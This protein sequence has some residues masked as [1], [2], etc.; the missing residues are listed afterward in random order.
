M[1]ET[2][3]SDKFIKINPY[4]YLLMLFI[5]LIVWIKSLTNNKYFKYFI[6]IYSIFLIINLYFRTPSTNEQFSTNFYLKKWFKLLFKNKIVFINVIGNVLLFIPLG[7]IVGNLKIRKINIVI[8][9]MI[10]ILIIIALE[11]IQYF[12]KLGVFDFVDILLNT[13]GYLI[14]L[15]LK[16]KNI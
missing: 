6:L 15:I 2:L 16:R 14:G 1:H 11:L 10:G 9:I 12:T 13:I 4:I 7:Y 5:V 8:K 3:F